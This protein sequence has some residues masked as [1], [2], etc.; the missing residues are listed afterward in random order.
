MVVADDSAAGQCF[1][2]LVTGDGWSFLCQT[3]TGVMAFGTERYVTD[4]VHNFLEAVQA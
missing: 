3:I 4:A 2:E 1:D